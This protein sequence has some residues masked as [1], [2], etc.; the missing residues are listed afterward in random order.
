[1]QEA[2]VSLTGRTAVVI[3]ASDRCAAGTQKDISGP[4]LARLLGER[5][6][7]VVDLKV[8]PDDRNLLVA[9]LRN[10]SQHAD[11]VLTTGGTGLAERDVIPEATLD[12]CHRLVPGIAEQIRL[13]GTQQTPFAALSRGVSGVSGR[14]LIIN[15]PGS[16]AGAE[17][18]LRSILPL[19]PHALD[20][21]AGHT[22]HRNESA[23]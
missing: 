18:G 3:T 4:L 15:L 19:L 10:A 14:A 6:A 8:I 5:G 2:V 23:R 22:E 17:S 11:L 21:L 12:V 7:Q 16:P 20:L 9:A 13:H 1:M